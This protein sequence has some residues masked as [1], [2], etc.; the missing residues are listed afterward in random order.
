MT[1]VKNRLEDCG[2]VMGRYRRQRK[3][4]EQ[5]VWG[6]GGWLSLSIGSLMFYM[7]EHFRDCLLQ[8]VFQTSM[9]RLV[10]F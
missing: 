8:E 4:R 1:E 3:E 5:Q 7:S 9:L 6:D 2:N 10:G